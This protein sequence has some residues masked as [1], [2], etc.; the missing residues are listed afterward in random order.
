MK[1]GNS[2]NKLK[3][4]SVHKLSINSKN[5][6]SSWS[7][8]LS[9]DEWELVLK[10]VKNKEVIA[11]ISKHQRAKC[12]LTNTI[13]RKNKIIKCYES[14]IEESNTKIKRLERQ[15]QEFDEK[16]HHLKKTNVSTLSHSKKLMHEYCQIGKHFNMMLD[17]IEKCDDM[18]KF[19]L[20]KEMSKEKLD[21]LDKL[22]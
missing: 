3:F 2:L 8:N 13:T 22:N 9:V 1:G 14:E 16:I 10:S 21:Y 6:M 15:I 7:V 5:T 11:K 18:S 4:E 17:L 19:G 12:N 20:L